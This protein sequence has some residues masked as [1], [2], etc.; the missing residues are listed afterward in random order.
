MRYI[1][2]ALALF[3]GTA[4]AWACNDKPQRCESYWI[5]SEKSG[6]LVTKCR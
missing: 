1:I 6:R 4:P 5:G 2:L 3:L